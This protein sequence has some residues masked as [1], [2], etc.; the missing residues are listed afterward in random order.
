MPYQRKNKYRKY[1]LAALKKVIAE[2][3]EDALDQFYTKNHINPEDMHYLGSGSFGEAYDIGH[4]KVLKKTTSKSEYRLAQ[5]IQKEKPP[6]FAAVFD[7]AK[8]GSDFYIVV[9]KLEIDSD[10]E[11]LFVRVMGMLETQ[12][13]PIPYIG[14]FDEDEYIDSK[15]DEVA[16]GK[17]AQD[18]VKFMNELGD[19]ARGY[20]S[21]GI[22]AADISSE[23]LGRDRKGNLK[24]FDID[25][26]DPRSHWK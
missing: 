12:E 7:T 18:I 24:A 15:G 14:H 2:K 11:D 6:A 20:R 13:I 17:I 4:G 3:A 1:L 19:V 16:D 9:E 22:E 23:N 25:D 21:L 8:I 10:I 5:E 26:R